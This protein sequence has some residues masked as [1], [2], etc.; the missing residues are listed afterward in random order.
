MRG[1][2]VGT[3]WNVHRCIDGSEGDVGDDDMAPSDVD[4]GWWQIDGTA[5]CRHPAL[6][7]SLTYLGKGLL[8]VLRTR[9]PKPTLLPTLTLLGP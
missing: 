9:N 4:G 5:V 7:Q 2:G 3:Q 6:R 1:R 8:V